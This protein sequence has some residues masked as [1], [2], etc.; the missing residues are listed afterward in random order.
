MMGALRFVLVEK[1]MMMLP[2][3]ENNKYRDH[4]PNGRGDL[5]YGQVYNTDNFEVLITC[6]YR[7]AVSRL[8]VCTKELDAYSVCKAMDYAIRNGIID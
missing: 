6:S 7:G 3:K 2:P 1:E 5:G 4:M 8:A